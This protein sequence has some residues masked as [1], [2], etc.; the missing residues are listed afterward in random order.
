M[1]EILGKIIL[2]DGGY[3][4]ASA[5]LQFGGNQKKILAGILPKTFFNPPVGY[6][7]F[8]KTL[9]LLKRV[10]VDKDDTIILALDKTKSF[11][12]LFYPL[13]KAQRK[14]LRDDQDHID[15]A[16]HYTQIDKVVEQIKESTDW[17]VMWFPWCWNTADLF[18]T[19]EGQEFLKEEEIEKWDEWY[20]LEADDIIAYAT[21]YFQDK[22]VIIVATDADLQMLCA[23]PNVKFFS[24]LVKCKAGKGAYKLVDNGYKILADK[25]E[26]GDKSDNIIPG[27]TDDNSPE[28][29]RKRELIIDLLNLPEFV[30]DKLKEEFD[31]LEPKQLIPENLPFQKSLACK[32]N[33]IYKPDKIITYD[34]SLK[35]HE[36]RK[37]KSKK[38]AKEKR[39]AKKKLKI[40]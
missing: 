2:L 36:K 38:Q 21:E 12:K 29:L 14:G 8:Q 34:E 35:Y 11:R 20:G 16:F 28:A 7:F 30:K 5:I 37:K 6:T 15:W 23:K 40:R 25:I 1:V 22:E 31:K 33:D 19:K 10:G 26:K 18:F 39:E 9:G 24:P 17:H 3:L 32:F 27:E 4:T 13:Y